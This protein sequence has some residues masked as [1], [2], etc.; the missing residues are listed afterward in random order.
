MTILPGSRTQEVKSNLPPLLKAAS[1][2]RERVPQV[3]FAIAAYKK[4]QRKMV[5]Q[6]VADGKVAA[7]VHQGRTPELIQAAHSCLACSGSVSLEL[8]Y[9]A[10]PAVIL[11]QVSRWGFFVQSIFR[12]VRYI[13]L[14]NLLTADDPFAGNE[15][16]IYHPQDPRD[17]HVLMP[18]YLTCEDR[19]EEIAGHVITWLTEESQYD[20]IVRRLTELKTRIAQGG[21]SQ[22]AAEYI[23]NLAAN[24]SVVP[25]RRSA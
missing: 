11:Y 17:A 18:E 9:H 23:T 4:S 12:K 1:R 25:L 24:S 16:G 14:V 3:R 15:A 2:I 19:A 13:T 6:M 7:E 21:A 8:L 10:R 20:A 5:E 22:R